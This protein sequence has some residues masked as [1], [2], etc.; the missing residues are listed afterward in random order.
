[1]TASAG[2]AESLDELERRFLAQPRPDLERWRDRARPHESV[3]SFWTSIRDDLPEAFRSGEDQRSFALGP[4]ERGVQDER[5]LDLHENRMRPVGAI[6]GNKALACFVASAASEVVEAEHHARAFAAALWTALGQDTPP[7]RVVWKH[8]G[9]GE[10]AWAPR[11]E[12]ALPGFDRLLNEVG[13]LPVIEGYTPAFQWVAARVA[14]RGA[15]EDA[16]A[17]GRVADVDLVGPFHGVWR[18]GCGLAAVTSDCIVLFLSQNRSVPTRPRAPGVK[19]RGADAALLRAANQA[20]PKALQRALDLG[21]DPNVQREGSSAL[22][23]VANRMPAQRNAFMFSRCEACLRQLLEAG[24]DPAI[25]DRYGRMVVAALAYREPALEV[26]LALGM[27][28]NTSDLQGRTALHL[29]ARATYTAPAQNLL[30]AGAEVDRPDALG[31][32]PLHHAV[33]AGSVPT[34][35]VLRDAGADVTRATISGLTVADLAVGLANT[36]EVL[37][38]TGAVPSGTRR[39]VHAPLVELPDALRDALLEREAGG[40]SVLADWLEEQGDPRGEAVAMALAGHVGRATRILR[41]RADAWWAPLLGLHPDMETLL[42]DPGATLSFEH[43]F[44]SRMRLG[45]LRSDGHARAAAALLGSPAGA[46]ITELVVD[47]S[48][49]V[50]GPW[51]LH[52][53]RN[54]GLERAR[55][56]RIPDEVGDLDLRGLTRLRALSLR[57]TSLQALGLRSPH[58]R[59]LTVHLPFLRDAELQPPLDHLDTPELTTLTLVMHRAPDPDAQ[60]MIRRLDALAP[61]VEHLALRPMSVEALDALLDGTLLARLRTLRLESMLGVG[62]RRV[63]AHAARFAHLEELVLTVLDT[64]KNARR[65]LERELRA[66]LPRA[67]LK[68]VSY[69]AAGG[70]G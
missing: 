1:M 2:A 8:S 70:Y 61:T 67:T 21:A 14:A 45:R 66:V 55:F 57:G 25:P 50:A 7:E 38:V 30:R 18:T 28:V 62:L 65:V 4:S 5:V 56:D 37:A 19:R 31:W 29:S 13:P 12:P 64:D 43:G 24:A 51:M 53:L 46:L 6:P 35:R 52:G 3:E 16:R 36:R 48:G 10:T 41:D 27:D 59:T 9:W 58:L 44:A 33:A 63:V 54:V 11:Q 49:G 22:H 69:R 60:R 68:G 42:A 34:A 26:G 39:R 17:D 20:D 47:L 15:W 32:T 40:W 23:R